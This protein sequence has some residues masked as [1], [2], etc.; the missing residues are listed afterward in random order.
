M[1][2]NPFDWVSGPSLGPFGKILQQP[3]GIVLGVVW[4][5][6]IVYSIVHLAIA[7]GQL[8]AARR[9]HRGGDVEAS[10]Q[11][12]IWPSAAIIGLVA[13]PAIYLVLTNFK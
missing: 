11:R 9:E 1:N 10:M 6:A 5:L 8:S 7:I 2:F 3:L 4:A 13:L 12:I